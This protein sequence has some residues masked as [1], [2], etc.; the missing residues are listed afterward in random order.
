MSKNTSKRL[1]Q[2]SISTFFSSAEK[3][4]SSNPPQVEKKQAVKK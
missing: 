4:A 1:P 3:K 2:A